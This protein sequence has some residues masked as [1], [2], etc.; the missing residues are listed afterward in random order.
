M[1]V[2]ESKLSRRID[3]YFSITLQKIAGIERK[4]NNICNRV[5]NTELIDPERSSQNSI[6]RPILKDEEIEHLKEEAIK[7]EELK[8]E[9]GVKIEVMDNESNNEPSI[10]NLESLPSLPQ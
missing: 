5:F 4:M 8:Q 1:K 3:H 6:N 10:E 7:E 2:L 9:T